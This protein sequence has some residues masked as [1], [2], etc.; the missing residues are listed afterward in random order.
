[1]HPPGKNRVT[2]F[3]GAYP[4]A[5]GKT[6]TSMMSMN[7]I[8]GDDIAYLRSDDRGNCRAVNIEQGIFGI[9]QDVNMVDDPVI[10][11]A[12]SSPRELIFSNVLVAEGVPYWS[13]M[14]IPHIPEKGTNFSGDWWKGKKDREGNEIS[15][16]HSNARY[17]MR[18]REL[19]NVDQ[20][21]DNPEGVIV[22]AILFGG[23]DS[24]TN[25]P[26]C[27]AI[28]W[29]HGVYLGATIESETTS[30]IQGKLGVRR[31]D[32][33]ANI[34]FVS[35]PLGNYLRNYLE[36]GEKLTRKPSIF[37]TNY[38]L[39]KDG[40]YANTKL[41]K[42][43]WI[44]WAEGRISNEF[45]CIK[46]PFGNIPLYEDLEQLFESV[47][48]KEYTHENY[49]QQFGIRINNHLAKI[50]RMEEAFSSEANVPEEIWNILRKQKDELM[51]LKDDEKNNV[52]DPYYFN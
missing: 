50:S 40:K 14:G 26:I 9:I 20:M 27:E 16:A 36:F 2:Y 34:D 18:L 39:R 38:F 4:S 52:I 6:S 24:D 51:K 42:M 13:G 11:G 28:N 48:K 3:A 7:T 8:V 21:F 41:D 10:F 31:H 22:E 5:C 19:E 1:V 15:F 32:P 47:L 43:I 12:L 46:T 49:A 44:L 23:R 35:V 37:A 29:E 33:M 45:G 17:T 25:V 30:A